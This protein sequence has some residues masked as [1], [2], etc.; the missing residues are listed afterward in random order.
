L[1]FAKTLV[2]RGTQPDS[3]IPVEPFRLD[4]TASVQPSRFGFDLLINESIY[5]FSFSVSP[6][7]VLEEKLVK[8]TSA[9]E[10]TIL[11]EDGQNIASS[12]DC[13][14]RLIRYI[15]N[16]DKV[17]KIGAIP[18]EYISDAVRRAEKRDNPTCEDWPRSIGPTA[19][20]RPVKRILGTIN[21]P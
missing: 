12:K 15:P 11:F 8:I 10:K 3:L 17:V 2:V 7:E 13:S 1:N 6:R 18:Q 19:V 16:Y 9:G 5:E 14:D 21:K 20:Y 4:Q